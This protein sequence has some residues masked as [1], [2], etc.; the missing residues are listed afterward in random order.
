MLRIVATCLLTV[1]GFTA[2]VE[3]TPANDA[4]AASSCMGLSAQPMF[5]CVNLWYKNGGGSI[6]RH[7]SVMLHWGDG[8]VTWVDMAQGTVPHT[9]AAAGHYTIVMEPLSGCGAGSSMSVPVQVQAAPELPL[10]VLPQ[11]LQQIRVLTT[12]QLDTGQTLRS[13][14]DWGDGAPLEAFEW[15]GCT[16]TTLCTPPHDYADPGEYTLRVRVEYIGAWEGAC[17]EREATLQAVIGVATPVHTATW[18]AIKALYR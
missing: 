6:P 5:L 18:G 14:I 7:E 8:T 10:V 1:A 3:A 11:G 12:E 16:E 2:V 17:Y 13:T 4:A 15:T 9:Y